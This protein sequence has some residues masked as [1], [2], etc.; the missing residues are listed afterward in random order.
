MRRVIPMLLI[1]GALGAWAV[2]ALLGGALSRPLEG[3]VTET[4]QTE[5]D[6]LK[7]RVERRAE[8]DFFIP[9]AY[10]VFMSAQ[11]GSKKWREIFTFRHDDPVP[12]PKEQVR[13][14]GKGVGYVYMGW[15]Y[16]VTTDA[17]KSWSVW[18]AA[19]NLPE[20]SCCNYG[21]I[22][23]VGIE[24][25]GKGTMILN[26]IQGRSGEVGQLHTTDFGRSW[27]P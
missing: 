6:G 4:W 12:I 2:G 10:Y 15:M 8:R 7:V 18:D 9:G 23:S 13:L 26:P 17:G 21:L 22:A 5:Y 14:V 24:P 16:A 25:D 27:H 11:A 3:G 20:W 19:E 1:A